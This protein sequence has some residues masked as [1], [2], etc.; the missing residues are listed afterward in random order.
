MLT[1][2]ELVART[3][4]GENNTGRTPVYGWV[5]ANL[6]E[7]ISEKFGS[8]ENFE[9]VYE[10]DMAHIFGGPSSFNG[11]EIKRLIESGEEITPDILLDIPL[12]PV[13]NMA[14][15]KNIADSLKHHKE[16]DRFCYVQTNGIFECLNSPFGIE[17]HLCYL[18]MYPDELKEVYA[19]QAEWN[20]Q[21]A[22]NA[23]ELGVDMV[24][25]SDDWGAQNSLMFSTNMWKEMIYPYHKIVCD[26]VKKSGKFLSLHSDGNVSSVLD[27]I[28]D[29]GFDVLHPWQEA[30][31]MSYDL[32]LEKYRDKLA[33]LGGICIQMTLGFGDFKNVENEIRRVFDTLKGER[34]LCCTTHFVQDHCS[35]EELIFAFDL[36]VKLA[37]G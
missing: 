25:I 27:G 9:D 16:R 17:D 4:R 31:G 7:V 33:I 15:Y 3:I 36:A 18:V 23:I 20:R 14:D 11:D 2:T 37:R 26:F 19:R 8:V 28:V 32:Y 29:L 1:S 22:A 24:H 13:N 21:F 30:A 10:Y 6:K 12:N 34:W 35:I 5:G